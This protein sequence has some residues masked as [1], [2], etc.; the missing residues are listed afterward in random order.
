MSGKVTTTSHAD[1]IMTFDMHTVSFSEL[2]QMAT[3]RNNR[4]TLDVHVECLV[5]RQRSPRVVQT[6]NPTRNLKLSAPLTHRQRKPLTT[7][8]LLQKRWLIAQT[9]TLWHGEP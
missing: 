1:K 3:N 4:A 9:T 6:R 5:N 8:A 2:E 7:K